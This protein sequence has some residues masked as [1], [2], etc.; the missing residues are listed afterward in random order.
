MHA[1]NLPEIML[2]PLTK[3]CIG[4]EVHSFFFF[5]IERQLRRKWLPILP[6]Q[7]LMFNRSSA[8]ILAWKSNLQREKNRRTRR[9]TRESDWDRQISAQVRTRSREVGCATDDH[10]A[11][12]TPQTRNHTNL[13]GSR[14]QQGQCIP[15]FLPNLKKYRL[16]SLYVQAAQT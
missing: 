9:K 12:L 15:F 4:G 10:Y 11:N 2:K 5:F 14:P 13:E 1:C 7:R 6:S 16:T 3:H 8:Q